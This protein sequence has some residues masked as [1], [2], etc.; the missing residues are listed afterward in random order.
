VLATLDA[1]AVGEEAEFDTVG[2]ALEWSRERADLVLV[3]MGPS[4]REMYS[5][6]DARAFRGE[7]DPFPEWPPPGWTEG[8]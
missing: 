8:S 2:E 7:D 1:G 5:A 3:R 6:G 4:D